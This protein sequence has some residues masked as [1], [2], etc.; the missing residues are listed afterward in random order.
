M[1]QCCKK[2]SRLIESTRVK[3]EWIISK[4]FIR[5]LKSHATSWGEIENIFATRFGAGIDCCKFIETLQCDLT[6]ITPQ[7]NFSILIKWSIKRGLKKFKTKSVEIVFESY[8]HTFI[9]RNCFML[10]RPLVSMP[11]M[12]TLRRGSV[13]GS[14]NYERANRK[15]KSRNCFAIESSHA[16]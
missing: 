13:N 9:N 11:E 7:K 16:T 2:A 5:I 14:G 12:P 3:F 8:L 1:P 6:F 10:S 4:V 15:S